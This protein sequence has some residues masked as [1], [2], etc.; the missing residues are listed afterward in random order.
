M[1]NI[2]YTDDA[3]IKIVQNDVVETVRSSNRFENNTIKPLGD[4]QVLIKD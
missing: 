2:F 3:N 1:D 4:Y